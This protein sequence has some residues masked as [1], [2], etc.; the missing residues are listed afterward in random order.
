[1]SN[2]HLAIVVISV[3]MIAVGVIVQP[4]VKAIL[5]NLFF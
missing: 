3:A 5:M 4:I 1:M 2:E